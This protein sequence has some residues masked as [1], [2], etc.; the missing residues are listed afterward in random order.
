MDD[1][2]A[3]VALNLIP[4]LGPVRLRGLLEAFSSPQ[5]ILS[6]KKEQLLA[7]PGVGREVAHSITDWEG[8]IDLKRELKIAEEDDVSILPLSSPEYP[9]LLKEIHDPPTV[10]YMKGTLSSGDKNAIGVV[11]SRKASHYALEMT[12]KISHQLAHHGLTVV[13]GLARGVDAAAHQ[14]ALAARGRTLGV[15]GSGLRRLYPPE[16]DK[17]AELISDSGA[18]L[19]EFPMEKKADRTTFPMRNRIIT[20]LSFGLLVTEAAPNSG[21]LISANQ[22]GEQGRSL[23]AIPGRIDLPGCIGSNRLIQQ[24]AKLVMSAEDILDDLQILFAKEPELASP[25]LPGGLSEAERAVYEA[26]SD[27]EA[28]VDE[29]IAKTGLPAHTVTATLLRL[30]MRLLVRQLPGGRFVQ[31]H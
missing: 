20:G 5:A 28:L 22:A 7:V 29:L 31:L 26:F 19:T 9:A 3:F 17:L 21:A 10:L 6:A 25:K 12:K 24:G 18:V 8:Q 13:S 11:G 14:G 2:E 16:H 15:I 23:Y 4:R 27:D 30:E 1:T